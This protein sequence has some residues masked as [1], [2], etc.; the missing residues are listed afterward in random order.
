M[1]FKKKDDLNKQVHFIDK[2]VTG[3]IIGW[4]IASIVWLSKK[5]KNESFTKNISDESTKIAK[6]WI[7]FFGRILVGIVKIFSKKK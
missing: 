2:L 6:K 7:N 1:F 4:A 5:R 3:L